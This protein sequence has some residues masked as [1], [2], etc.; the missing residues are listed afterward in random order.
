MKRQSPI[1]TGAFKDFG[2]AMGNS[3]VR[4]FAVEHIFIMI[5]AIVLAH[6]GR[7]LS[8]KAA[9]DKSKFKRAAIFFTLSMLAVLAA[10]PWPFMAAGAGR[11]WL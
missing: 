2:A 9:D 7:S 10:I 1:T 8:K 4:F 5:V 11:G 6:V 3:S